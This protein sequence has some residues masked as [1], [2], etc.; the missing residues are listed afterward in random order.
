MFGA[1]LK[2]IN[3]PKHYNSKLNIAHLPGTGL[4]ESEK[5]HVKMVLSSDLERCLGWKTCSARSDTF[6][7]KWDSPCRTGCAWEHTEIFVGKWCSQE[8][9]WPFWEHRG[10]TECTT[11]TPSCYWRS[12]GVTGRTLGLRPVE[13]CRA[14]E[15]KLPQ[16]LPSISWLHEQHTP[17]GVLVFFSPFEA[18]DLEGPLHWAFWI[19]IMTPFIHSLVK[20]ISMEGQR[21]DWFFFYELEIQCWA[22]PFPVLRLL[23]CWG[24]GTIIRSPLK[25]TWNYTCDKCQRGRLWPTCVECLPHQAI[26]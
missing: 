18:I 9:R 21:W 5:H 12:V 25:P 8:L 14:M 10:S 13:I 20:Q 15:N 4:R 22:K 1:K 3:K 11:I 16:L 19:T 23:N 2:K 24:R 6:R 17:I 26:S 7:C